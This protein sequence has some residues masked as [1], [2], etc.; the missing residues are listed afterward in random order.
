MRLCLISYF[1]AVL[2]CAS[3]SVCFAQGIKPIECRGDRVYRDNR[4]EGGSGQVFCEHVLPGSLTVKDGPFRFWFNRDFEGAS[5]NYNEGREIGKWNECDRFE[6]CERKDYPAIY[7][8]EKQRSGFKPEIPVAFLNG[9]Y[10]FDFASCR[11]TWVTYNNGGKPDL[12]LNIGAQPNG[13]F[14]AYIRNGIG[15]YNCTIP[16]QVGRGEFDSLDLISELPKAGLPQY[17]AK[18]VVKTGPYMSSV[19]PNHGEGAAQVYTAEFSLGNNGVSIA[20]ARLHFQERAESRS[21]RC[22]ARYDPGS[23]SLFLL[24]DQP[25][26]YLGPIAAGGKASLWNS[27]CLLAGCSNAEVTNDTLKVHF[28]IRFNSAQFAGPHNMFLEMVDTDKHASPAPVYGNWTVP[29]ESGVAAAEWPI[30]RS[31]PV[32]TPVPPLGVYTSSVVNCKDVSGTWSDAETG[33]SWSLSQTGDN[34][35]GSLTITKPECGGVT[36]K[37]AGQ[38]KNGVATLTATG[39]SPAVD[40]CGQT[41]ANSITTTLAPDCKNRPRQS[42]N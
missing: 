32:A 15:D 11:S 38:M 36:W 28:A 40:N 34:I 30:D 3:I 5:G 14:I 23:N 16:L 17:C 31:C 42:G 27:R 12:E 41:A 18:Q 1:S 35:S 20:Q 26:K 29:A 37:V 22:V 2:V 25:G 7:P 4:T 19:D 9:K 33:G 39:P 6:R 13:C 21:N 24:S 8:E 10:V